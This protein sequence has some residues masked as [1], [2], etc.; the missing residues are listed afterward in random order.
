M[1][2]GGTRRTPWILLGL[3]LAAAPLSASEPEAAPNPLLEVESFGSNPGR[4]EMYVHLPPGTVAGAPLVVVAHGCFQ[5]ARQ[6]AASSGWVEL[7]DRHRFA[8]LFPQTSKENEPMGGCFRTWQP[9][10][11]RR[12]GG[13]PVSIRQMIEWMLETYRLDARRVFVTGMSS[14]GLVTNVLL[15]TYPELFAA[16]ASLSGYPYDCA[17]SFE[18]VK[19]CCAGERPLDSEAWAKL[20]LDAR[21]GYAGP[22]PRVAIW[23]GDADTLLLP[24]NLRLQMEQWTR[25]LG[26]DQVPD[27]VD[28][29]GGHLRERFSD[30]S[31][32][33]V[34]E[35]FLIHG[36][37]HA[38]AVDPDGTPACGATG[39]Y[40]SDVDLCAALWI[41]RWFG[42]VR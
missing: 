14:G 42:I 22:R 9:Q 11:T 39:D 31:G 37:G 28:S 1:R 2:S 6:V 25:V 27:E 3:L 16:G 13:E 24:V 20:V 40:F 30:A 17:D 12:E 23:H 32:E 29:I 41:A 36:M 26:V 38:L 21:P 33:P 19:S 4:L 7:A 18:T 15:A 35:T 10:Q 34:V 5:T 8:L